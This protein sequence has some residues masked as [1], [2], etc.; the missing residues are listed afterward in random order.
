MTLGK[1]FKVQTKC[2]AI[3]CVFHRQH[4]T[5]QKHKG[6]ALTPAKI[7]QFSSLASQW[8]TESSGVDCQVLNPQQ[9]GWT[10]N[11]RL[12]VNCYTCDS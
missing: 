9:Q 6:E 1:E 4:S 11:F 5:C 8:G 12:P 2:R 10:S 3:L 7:P